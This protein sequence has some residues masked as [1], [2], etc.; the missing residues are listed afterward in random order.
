[1]TDDASPSL[2]SLPRRVLA[3]FVAPGQLFRQLRDQ[4]V[5]AGALCV[6]AAAI[7]VGSGLSFT[8]GETVEEELRQLIAEGGEEFTGSI[9]GV[10]IGGIFMA[11]AMTFVYAWIVAGVMYVVFARVLRDGGNGNYRQYLAVVS[12]ATIVSRAGVL[13]LLPA[14]LLTGDVDWSLNLAALAPALEEGYLLD[15]LVHLDVFQVWT[16]LLMGLGASKIHPGRSWTAAF[17][18]LLV[19]SVL[20][21]VGISALQELADGVQT[22]AQ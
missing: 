21:A 3:V 7:M 1:M 8:F 2:P 15:V 22:A 10:I 12:H 4:P 20:S 13:V 18:I 11:G 5:W 16:L 14:A 6:A 17:A 9:T 19:I